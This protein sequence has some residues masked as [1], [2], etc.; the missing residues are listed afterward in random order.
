MGGRGSGRWFRW[1]KRPTLD[2]VCSLDIRLLK[3]RGLL[4]PGSRTL[5]SWSRGA[6][7]SGIATRGLLTFSFVA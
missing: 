1:D 6:Q 2:E 5:W 4:Q 3:R 7:S